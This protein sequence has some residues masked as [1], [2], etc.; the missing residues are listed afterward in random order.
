[1]IY[2]EHVTKVTIRVCV[3]VCV[4]VRV[5]VGRQIMVKS[6]DTVVHRLRQEACIDSSW[7]C[8]TSTLETYYLN[9]IARQLY[10]QNSPYSR[11]I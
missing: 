1:M 6:F 5:G 8:S 9:F 7:T 2:G 3:R 11:K 10:A 4:Y